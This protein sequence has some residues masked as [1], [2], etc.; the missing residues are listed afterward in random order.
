MKRKVL[1]MQYC[2]E[3]LYNYFCKLLRF[4][5]KAIRKETSKFWENAFL[6]YFL[7]SWKNFPRTISVKLMLLSKAS[8]FQSFSCSHI[9]RVKFH[10]LESLRCKSQCRVSEDLFKK[11]VLVK[12]RIIVILQS[13]LLYLFGSFSKPTEPLIFYCKSQIL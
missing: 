5:R 1:A 4:Q 6:T 7:F 2:F 10:D 9:L 11:I 13:C 8:D 3:K 12:Q